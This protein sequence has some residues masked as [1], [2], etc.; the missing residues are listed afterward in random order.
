MGLLETA[1]QI[2]GAQEAANAG[3]GTSLHGF[4][5]SYQPVESVEAVQDRLRA[6]AERYAAWSAT[7]TGRFVRAAK[8][9]FDATGDERLL[10]CWTRGLDTNHD[11]AA[12]LLTE[13]KGPAADQARAA[14]RDWKDAQ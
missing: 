2:V 8:L 6:D 11:F 3:R 9:V 12:K 1:R 14:L 10:Q 5:S 13:M 7:A 4:A